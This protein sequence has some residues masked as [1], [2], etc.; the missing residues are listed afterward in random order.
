MDKVLESAAGPF[1]WIVGVGAGLLTVC[2]LV[3][4]VAWAIGKLSNLGAKRPKGW[5]PAV[6][7]NDAK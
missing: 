3:I 2:L 7:R 4:A 6:V 5:K 1:G